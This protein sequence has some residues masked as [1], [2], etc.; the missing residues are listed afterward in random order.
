MATDERRKYPRVPICD[1]IS[2]VAIDSEG[3][4]LSQNLGAVQNASQNGLKIETYDALDSEFAIIS[5]VD[6]EKNLVEIKGRVV[7]C[8]QKQTGRFESGI[9]LEGSSAEK[10]QFIKKLVRSYHYTKKDPRK[11]SYCSNRDLNPKRSAG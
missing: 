3:N 7:Y 6:F 1:P 10:I 5:F 8:K 9:S 4:Y 2:Y 11:F